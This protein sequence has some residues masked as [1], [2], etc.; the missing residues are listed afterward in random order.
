VEADTVIKVETADPEDYPTSAV[1]TVNLAALQLSSETVNFSE[2]I[3]LS[4]TLKSWQAPGSLIQLFWYD[5]AGETLLDSGM[6]A[7]VDET[8][9][10]ASAEIS[11]MPEST[12]GLSTMG[13]PLGAK[14]I[15]AAKPLNVSK[16][17]LED[18][19]STVVP[20]FYLFTIKTHPDVPI[21]EGLTVPFQVKRIGGAG[22]GPGPFL[23]GVSVKA[24]TRDGTKIPINGIHWS[25]DGWELIGFMDVPVLPNCGAGETKDATL[26]ITYSAGSGTP[27]VMTLGFEI[28]CLC[29]LEF[30][31]ATPQGVSVCGLMVEEWVGKRAVR[32]QP[33]QTY[34]F[35]RVHVGAGGVLR[36][37]TPSPT[38]LVS[39][40]AVLEVTGDVTVAGEIQTHAGSNPYYQQ[41][42]DGSGANDGG[43]PGPTYGCNAGI[44]GYGAPYIVMVNEPTCFYHAGIRVYCCDDPPCPYLSKGR[45]QDGYSALTGALGGSGGA[46]WEKGTWW[47]F[48]FNL[49]ESV[50]SLGTGAYLGAIEGTYGAGT[51]LVRIYKNEE[52]R[53]KSA[54]KGGNSPPWLTSQ[55][56]ELASFKPPQAG[57][58][59]GGSGKQYVDCSLLGIDFCGD[60]AGGGGG[61]GGG[62]APG[63]KMVVDGKVTIESGGRIYGAGG[64]GGPGGDGA[65][66]D[67]AP[68]GGG[69][70]GNGAQILIIAD[71]VRNNGTIEAPGGIGGLSGEMKRDGKI[72]L[73]KSGF[74]ENGQRGILRVDGEY[75][76]NDPSNIHYYQGPVQGS[77]MGSVVTAESPWCREVFL[78]DFPGHAQSG[79]YYY[80][81]IVNGV[82]GP[83]QSYQKPQGGRPYVT[84]CAELQPGLNTVSLR[85]NREWSAIP[86]E[87]KGPYIQLEPWER[88]YVFY[89]P[90]IVDSDGDGILDGLEQNL[91]TNPFNADSDKDGLND[92]AEVYGPTDPLN[93]DTDGDGI[94]DGVEVS[95]GSDP[96]NPNCTPEG[97]AYGNATCDG[98]DND[99]DGLTDEGFP[100]TDHDGRADCVDSDND[101][102]G[103]T[104]L[105]ESQLGTNPLL[106]DTDGDGFSDGMEVTAGTNPLNSNSYP[107]SIAFN[108]PE[109]EAGALFG[110]AIAN[111]GDIDGRGKED[112]L[113][114]APNKGVGT[115]WNAGKVYLFAGEDNSL[116]RSFTSPLPLHTARFG[117]AIAGINDVND[118]GVPDI[119]IGEPFREIGK[120]HLFSGATGALIR[121]FVPG[122]LQQYTHFGM[123]VAAGPG[124]VWGSKCASRGSRIII[125]EPH[126]GHGHAYVFSPDGTLLD[127]LS[128]P[129]P[130][131]EPVD[132]FGWAV[133]VEGS[134]E[135]R[136][137]GGVYCIVRY[138]VGAPGVRSGKGKSHL[139]TELEPTKF[140]RSDPTG[141]LP[142]G[143]RFG[144]ALGHLD[145][146]VNVDET[147]FA[148][149]APGYDAGQGFVLMMDYAGYGFIEVDPYPLP[150]A[151]AGFGSSLTP[152]RW[153]PTYHYLSPNHMAMLAVGAPGQGPDEGMVFLFAGSPP[154]DWRSPWVEAASVGYLFSPNPQDGAA[155]GHAMASNGSYYDQ[156]MLAVSAPWQDVSG[157][158]DQGRVY[159][160]NLSQYEV[161]D[162]DGDGL[163]DSWER[164]FGSDPNDA[165]GDDDGIGDL[166]DNCKLAQN[167][168][169]LDTDFDGV[170]DPCDPV[171]ADT[172]PP[173]VPMNLYAL[174][175]ETGPVHLRVCWS[176]STDNEGVAG[177]HIYR[178]GAYYTSVGPEGSPKA[179]FYDT[180]IRYA[181]RYYC[182]EVTAYDAAGNESA[183]TYPVCD[184]YFPG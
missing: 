100:D 10:R 171:P 137:E 107:G 72:F 50:F 79:V 140:T 151:S 71:Q 93:P 47:G 33:G 2:S 143:S 182:Y 141:D 19:F 88:Q 74:G 102:D 131:E 161:A 21:L 44:G 66:R 15:V 91:S 148:I 95:F 14:V 96:I 20:Y 118:D 127:V 184:G 106:W 29:E 105:Q 13:G 8:G 1:D 68:G 84:I 117:Y 162:N 26:E 81:V 104:D 98:I 58:G 142:P 173:T 49:A 22:S 99:L 73:I 11:K 138:R 129:D 53:L 63:L 112:W 119:L 40:P 38:L 144:S 69:G 60:H 156:A 17:V 149:G 35:S 82:E 76:G 114:S 177:Y 174:L 51:E 12:S 30:S 146:L 97:P 37:N 124:P 120:V 45:G 109:P 158:M 67:A 103:L 78:G 170:G 122:H 108:L 18:H 59:G 160:F 136:G 155:F 27:T 75:T 4:F 159:L 147:V 55:D 178:D 101:N 172:E 54:G 150:R 70:G 9:I 89:L 179:C 31:G 23:E 183:K 169:Q 24:I 5:Q 180:D 125:G 94:S 80:R 85:V 3:K 57:G 166:I 39:Q 130:D 154:R 152:V 153:F 167:P 175:G 16:A 132:E 77:V 135:D 6:T 86:G 48:V 110:F 42:Q 157:R 139:F 46:R 41:G 64:N 7:V 83:V 61:G 115:A 52:N 165:D 145:N 25:A 65:D 123:S 28:Q 90:G 34:R 168:D 164:F 62:G 126:R 133:S 43:D 113:I 116:I 121:S 163:Y 128:S 181:F 36:V 176:L 111:V 32:V 92:A 87:D 134:Y 56:L